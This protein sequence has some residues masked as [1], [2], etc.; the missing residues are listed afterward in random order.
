MVEMT[1]YIRKA[2][3]EDI[4]EKLGWM[5]EDTKKRAQLK[6]DKM[7]ESIAYSDEFLNKDIVD[8]LHKGTF[9]KKKWGAKC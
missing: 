1:R 5:D 8:N 2:F 3:K 4:L 9:V 7:E 6:L